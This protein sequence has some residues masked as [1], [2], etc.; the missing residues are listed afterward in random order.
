LDLFKN[1]PDL[2]AGRA[3]ALCRQGDRSA[4]RAIGDGAMAQ[5]GESAY[6]WMVRGELLLDRG[7]DTDKHCFEKALLCDSDPMVP[8]EIALICRHYHADHK[9]L[10][11]FR[12][13]AEM[14]PDNAT[15][16]HQRAACEAHL[17][18]NDAALKSVERCLSLKPKHEAG[19]RLLTT[20]ESPS[21]SLA[22]LWRRMF[23]K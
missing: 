18:F 12:K 13:A 19:L 2:L 1:Q 9:A 15:V 17:G 6:R 21:W 23:G 4:A 7:Q 16:W 5:P 20:L 8:L 14:A 22:R 3:Q 11:Y 10:V